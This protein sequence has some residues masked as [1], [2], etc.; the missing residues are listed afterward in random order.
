MTKREFKR[1]AWCGR[2]VSH[3]TAP[4]VRALRA[5]DDKGIASWR[6][7]SQILCPQHTKDWSQDTRW[8]HPADPGLPIEVRGS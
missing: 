7:Y 6:N 8:N 1:C 2:L 5:L 3:T 4:T